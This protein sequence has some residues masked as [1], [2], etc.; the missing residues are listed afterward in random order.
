[1][2]G[3]SGGL[4]SSHGGMIGWWRSAGSMIGFHARVRYIEMNGVSVEGRDEYSDGMF[5]RHLRLLGATHLT[6]M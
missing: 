4:I 3:I 2:D 1:M 5:D 6:L